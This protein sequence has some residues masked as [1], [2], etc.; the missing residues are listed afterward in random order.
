M[1]RKNANALNV[2][3]TQKPRKNIVLKILMSVFFCFAFCFDFNPA[4]G[5]FC[6]NVPGRKYADPIWI[7]FE[8]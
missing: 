8:D 7:K 4:L 6:R 5:Y 3:V 2:S 1:S